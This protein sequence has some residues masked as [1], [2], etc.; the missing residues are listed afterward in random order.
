MPISSFIA[1][2]VAHFYVFRGAWWR[3]HM[4]QKRRHLHVQPLTALKQPTKCRFLTTHC[5]CVYNCNWHTHENYPE[6]T[7]QIHS[8]HSL[9][10][11][12]RLSGYRRRL[13]FSMLHCSGI[14]WKPFGTTNNGVIW[15]ML[16]TE[17]HAAEHPSLTLKCTHWEQW[18]I[19][20]PL[21]PIMMIA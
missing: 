19:K 6:M 21:M 8:M 17:A 3:T 11:W 2:S 5:M 12:R 10:L 13:V 20:Q 4:D 18:A 15:Y 1:W 7:L 14:L 16:N 9:G